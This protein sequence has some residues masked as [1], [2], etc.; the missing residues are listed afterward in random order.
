MKPETREDIREALLV[1]AWIVGALL[2]GG[3]LAP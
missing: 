2:L 1:I 3:S